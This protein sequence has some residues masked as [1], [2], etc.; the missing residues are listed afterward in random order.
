V[1][2]GPTGV[3][4]IV[5]V[6]PEFAR[7]RSCRRANELGIDV[8]VTDHH[9]PR[10]SF[11]RAGV[12]IPT[13]PI[14]YTWKR[15]S[16]APGCAFK[17]IPGAAARAGWPPD[18]VRRVA[19]RFSAGAIATVADVV[20]LTGPET[21]SRARM[22]CAGLRHGAQPGLRALLEVAAS[23]PSGAQRAAGGVSNRAAHERRG[24]HGHRQRRG[25]S[26]PQTDPVRA[27]AWRGS[28]T[29]RTPSANSGSQV[30]D[31]WRAHDGA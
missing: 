5:S 10:P 11:P 4:L 28:F 2:A 14:A 18:K 16:A 15:T 17:V 12:L 3:K 25:W 23:P 9:L 26:L 20:P 30:R 27:R 21:V 7:A 24:P 1:E 31:I 22:V 13:G 19:N 6:I 8:I 29:T